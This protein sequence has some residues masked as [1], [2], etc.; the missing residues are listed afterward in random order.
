MVSKFYGF[1]FDRTIGRTSDIAKDFVDYIEQEDPVVGDALR[2]SQREIEASGG[3]FDMVGVL[4]GMGSHILGN[5]V[6]G[7]IGTHRNPGYLED[8]AEQLLSGV[9]D[10][11]H[12]SGIMTFGGE[13][14]Q[15]AKLRVSSVDALPHM[16]LDKKGVKGTLIASWYNPET[17]LYQLPEEFG[18]GFVEEVVLVDDKPVEFNG[19]PDLPSAKG[20]LFTGGIKPDVE[21]SPQ[22]V[23]GTLPRNVEEVASLYEITE[24]EGLQS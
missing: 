8:G 3:S 17:G 1:D 14:W 13:D 16:I 12:R 23:V 20:Y 5:C 4:R 10:H 7:F 11:G 19:F 9:T 18:G 21:T 22:P 24:K 6:E 2:M 15:T